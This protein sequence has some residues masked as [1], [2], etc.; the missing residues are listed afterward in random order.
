[1]RQLTLILRYH[2]YIIGE[3]LLGL[4][5]PGRTLG[6]A[7][8]GSAAEVFEWLLALGAFVWWRRRST[9]LL[10]MV[11]GRAVDEDRR[12][13]LA[14]PSPASRA[15]DFLVHVHRPLE[16]LALLFVLQWLLPAS[17]QAILEVR[18]LSVLMMWV[19]GAALIVDVVNALA[20]TGRADGP[21]REE[22]DSAALRLR[23]LRLVSRVV[24]VFGLVLVISTM[25]VGRGTIYQWVFSTCW[26][27]SIPIVLILVRWWR[28]IVF[29]RTERVRKPA[30]IQRWVLANSEGWWTSFAAAAVGGLYLFG[31]G[32]AARHAQPGRP[33]RHHA[34]RARL[35]VPAPARQA[36]A[37]RRR[38]SDRGRC[39]RGARA[40]ESV[41]EVDRRAT[42]TSRS[43]G[44]RAASATARVG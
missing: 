35:S 20:A 11:H 31:S 14:S 27:A 18:V 29:V 13:G 8:A 42:P 23:S 16:W 25:L 22:P 6:A 43:A 26:L 33:L 37:D 21:R 30:R 3:W 4:R 10:R 39:L 17:T 12:A 44:S 19:F 1:M 15:L 41:H 2:R 32:A 28:T 38:R 34:A 40:G 9:A 7:L 5:H 24:V 36:G